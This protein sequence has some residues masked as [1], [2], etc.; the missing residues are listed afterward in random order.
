MHD[1]VGHRLGDA[2]RQRVLHR[3]GHPLVLACDVALTGADDRPV[4]SAARA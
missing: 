1:D 2:E 3:A 4:G